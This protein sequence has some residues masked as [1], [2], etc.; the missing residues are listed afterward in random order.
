[1]AARVALAAGEPEAASQH[2]RD[3]HEADPTRPVP[4]F[5]RGRLLYAEGDYAG[6]AAA[7]EEAAEAMPSSAAPMADLHLY[8][9]ESLTQLDRYAEAE[10][11]YRRELNAFPRNVQAYAS[12]AMLYRASN[13]DDAVEDVLN[14]LVSG[15]PTPEGY[16]VAARL[17]TILGDPTRAEA[18]KSDARVR[19]RGDPLPAML[20]Q[21]ARQ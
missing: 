19:F 3:A 10:A 9:G 15:T 14:E 6:A 20:E 11:Q 21:G 8:L 18:L 1:M 2:A 13:R 7:F 5:V 17:W 16:A 4:Q 12:L